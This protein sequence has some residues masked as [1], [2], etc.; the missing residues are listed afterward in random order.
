MARSLAFLI[1]CLAALFAPLAAAQQAYPAKPVKLIVA[2]PPG[3][4]SDIVGRAL[5]QAMGTRLKQSFVV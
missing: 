1:F 2:Y 5:A 3:G 4:T